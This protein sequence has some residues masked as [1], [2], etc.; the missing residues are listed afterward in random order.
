VNGVNVDD[1]LARFRVGNDFVIIE[2]R[3]DRAIGAE[4]A[5]ALCDRRRGVGA[6]GVLLIERAP[7][8]LPRM[9]V[10]NADG[11]RPEMCGNGLRCVAAHLASASREPAR[12]LTIAT[13]AGPR[14]CLVESISP[15]VFDVTVAMGTARSTGELAVSVGGREHRFQKVDVGNPHAIS[16]EPFEDADLDRVGP[17][18]ATA[19]PGGTN[20]ELCRVRKVDSGPPLIEVIVWE[21]GVGRTLACGTGAC[22]ALAAACEAG[23]A[24]FGAPARMALPGGELLVTVGAERREIVMKGPAR[25]VFAGEVGSA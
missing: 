22:A 7:G 18:A 3:G 12:E 16:F 24:P 20:V 25:K 6:D 15:G 1:A 10:W 2:A 19:V 14:T 5:R 21:R 11:S 8:E 17:V 13:D 4:E 9:I 23:L